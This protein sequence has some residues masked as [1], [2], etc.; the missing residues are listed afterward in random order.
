[1]RNVNLYKGDEN[2]VFDV[3]FIL[4]MRNVNIAVVGAKSL[5]IKVLY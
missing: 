1:M 4:T 5:K 2:K 3:G